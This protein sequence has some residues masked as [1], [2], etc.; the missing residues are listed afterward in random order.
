MECRDS[1][2]GDGGSKASSSF[3][4]FESQGH[5]NSVLTMLNELRS[6]QEQC[7]MTLITEGKRFPCHKAVLIGACEYFR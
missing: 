6:K 4:I 1:A 3:I 2:A 7:D 5:C